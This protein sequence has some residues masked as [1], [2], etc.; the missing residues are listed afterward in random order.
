MARS[1]PSLYTFSSAR[2]AL[3][4]SQN[5]WCRSIRSVSYT[6]LATFCFRP[7]RLIEVIYDGEFV[8]FA[9]PVPSEHILLWNIPNGQV[10]EIRVD[11]YKRQ[12]WGAVCIWNATSIAVGRFQKERIYDRE[13]VTVFCRNKLSL[14]TQNLSLIHISSVCLYKRLAMLSSLHRWQSTFFEY[15]SLIHI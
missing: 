2:Y 13:K 7:W 8:T 5:G 10:I 11:V 9:E 14:Y 6:H 3:Y 12:A 4:Q 15:L 1:F